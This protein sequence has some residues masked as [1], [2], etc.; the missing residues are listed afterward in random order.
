[1]TMATVEIRE[2]EAGDAAAFRALN[3]EWI[4]RFFAIE[5]KDIETLGDPE[6]NILAHG[7]RIFMAI[8]DGRAGGCVAL[9][10]MG[11]GEFEIAKMAVTPASQGFGLGRK[12]MLRAI[13]AAR[14]DGATRLY[15]E[16]NHV[17]TPAIALYESVGF[18]HLPAGDSPYARANVRMEMLLG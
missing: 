16:T 18:R 3:E 12:L 2:F 7:G 9:L 11:Q 1:M 17:L 14:E 13:E 10:A 8:C 5:K 6:G 15:L 4:T